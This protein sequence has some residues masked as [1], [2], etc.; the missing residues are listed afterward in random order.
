M[1]CKDK[2]IVCESCKCT[3]D[4]DNNLKVICSGCE[5]GKDKIIICESCDCNDSDDKKE[6]CLNGCNCNNIKEDTIYI[7]CTEYEEDLD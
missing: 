6:I 1:S 4:E 5:D 7:T 2:K 3:Y